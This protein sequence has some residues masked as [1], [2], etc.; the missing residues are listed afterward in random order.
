MRCPRR[1]KQAELTRPRPPPRLRSDKGILNANDEYYGE[2]DEVVYAYVPDSNT[3][4][5]GL[6]NGQYQIVE[7]LE[8]EQY[9]TLA[10]NPDGYRQVND[11]RGPS[12]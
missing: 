4:V 8:P 2:G 11:L 12:D 10:K 7:R 5:L 6:L 3:S 1:R 9:Q